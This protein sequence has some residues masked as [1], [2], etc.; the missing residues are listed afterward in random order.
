MTEVF[1][2]SPHFRAAE[3]PAGLA[4]IV[5]DFERDFNAQGIATRRAAYVKTS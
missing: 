3:T 1:A 2:A 4:E 5:T